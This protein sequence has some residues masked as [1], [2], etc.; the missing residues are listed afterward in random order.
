MID[1]KP[2]FIISQQQPT[3]QQEPNRMRKRIKGT[4]GKKYKRIN[5]KKMDNMR[6]ESGS[7]D[8]H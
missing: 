6:P 8:I 2:A 3:T 1:T 7:I 5:N 4:I